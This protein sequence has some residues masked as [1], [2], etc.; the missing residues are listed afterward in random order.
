[1]PA[2]VHEEER[3]QARLTDLGLTYEIIYDAILAGE[4]A[5]SS[6]TANDPPAT[7]GILAWARTT[8]RFREGTAPLGWRASEA[9]QLSTCVDPTGCNAV[10]VTTG[11]HNT[12]N[13]HVEPKTKYPKGPATAAAIERNKLQLGLFESPPASE[14]PQASNV[15][16]WL[17]LLARTDSEI[18][19]EFS[20]PGH[21]GI[22]ERIESWTERIILGA[23]PIEPTPKFEQL[24][25][26]ADIEVD[27]KRRQSS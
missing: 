5:R 16:T 23:V 9:G 14:E 12:G 3:A 19:C 8:R 11:D 26:A 2:I 10:A 6:C 24:D 27:V 18:R 15:V 4:L 13:P 7:A 25:E 22:D 20:L 21:I 1:M 17:L